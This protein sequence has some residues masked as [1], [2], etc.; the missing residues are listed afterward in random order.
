MN[1]ISEEDF[2][3]V[4]RY[5]TI[6]VKDIVIC[7]F[8]NDD[9]GCRSMCYTDCKKCEDMN[10]KIFRRVLVKAVKKIGRIE[11]EMSKKEI[12]IDLGM[13]KEQEELLVPD[14]ILHTTCTKHK[15]GYIGCCPYCVIEVQEENEKLR[16]ALKVFVD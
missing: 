10:S 16:K 5:L 14:H 9:I 12:H 11:R 7:H 4:K 3:I 1:K 8:T 13:Y 15:I 2:N 6:E